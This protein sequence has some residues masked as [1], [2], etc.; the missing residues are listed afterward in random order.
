MPDLAIVVALLGL[1]IIGAVMIY[2]TTSY[3]TDL[4]NQSGFLKKQLLAEFLGMIAIMFIFVMP[5]EL[6]KI[7]GKKPF[8]KAKVKGKQFTLKLSY[9]LKKKTK[10]QVKVTKS[11]FKVFKKK[12]VVK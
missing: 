8:R 9:R 4:S 3:T 1:M 6:I 11:G 12:Y 2:S 5:Y 10:V 7:I